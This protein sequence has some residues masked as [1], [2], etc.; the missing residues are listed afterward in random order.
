MVHYSDVLSQ[1]FVLLHHTQPIIRQKLFI[2]EGFVLIS[3][4]IRNIFH[5]GSGPVGI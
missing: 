3:A 5:Y 1:M 2:L 4:E